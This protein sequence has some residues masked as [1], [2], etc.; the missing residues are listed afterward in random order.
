MKVLFAV[1]NEEIS[2]QIVKRYQ[3][4][5][6]EIISY[7]NV[8]Y[9]NAILKELQRDKSYDRIVISEDLEPFANNNYEM[10]DKFIFEKLDRISDEA[11]NMGNDIPIIL[12]SIERRTKSE[13]ILVKLF[14]LGIYNVLIGQDR[15]ISE[16]CKLLNK[17]R[18]K[19]DAK[20]YYKIES[21]EVNYQSENEDSVSE[22]EIQNILEHYRKL[23]NNQEKFVESFN[24][25]AAQYT[26]AQL[27]IIIK[28]LPLNVKA[29]L[30]ASSPKYQSIMT[31]SGIK[32]V[33]NVQKEMNKD[34]G[35]KIGFIESNTQK[36]K[37]GKPIVVPTALNIQNVKK[38]K[39]VK[40]SANSN[41]ELLKTNNN[42]TN[43]TPEQEDVNP[44]TKKGRG[45]PKK[46]VEQEVMLNADE[47]ENNIKESNS[48]VLESQKQE[49]AIIE[50]VAKK[51]R[52]RP[53]K[54]VQAV[55]TID[56]PQ[57]VKES[58]NDINTQLNNKKT[59]EPKD[60]ENDLLKL[61]Q[62]DLDENDS[63]ED[64]LENLEVQSAIINEEDDM[65]PGVGNEIADITD[66][67]DAN[68]LP[69]FD[70]NQNTSNDDYILPGVDD[71]LDD[72]TSFLPNTNNNISNNFSEINNDDDD[73]LDNLGNV[74]NSYNNSSEITNVENVT[75]YS[76]DLYG[77]LLTK[78]KKIVSFVGTSKNGT[79]FL[80]NNLA[81]LI[82]NMSIKTAI[83]DLTTNKNSYY[84]YTNNDEKLRN[85]A[86]DSMRNLKDGVAKGIPINK[87]LDVYTSLPDSNFNFQISEII[88]TLIK[89]YSLILIDCDFNTPIETFNISQEIYVV[90]SFDILTIQPMTAFLRDLKAKEIL[91]QEKIRIVLNKVVKMRGITSKAIIG[92]LSNY[93]DP[94]MSFMTELFSRDTV[95]YCE[96]SFDE[97]TYTRYLEGVVNC[98][99]SLNGYS[100]VFKEQ[101][102]NLGNMVY[103]LLNNK[104]K[105]YNNYNNYNNG[106]SV[107]I[108]NTLEQMKK[109]Y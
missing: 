25:I 11:N 50:P 101:L 109:Q 71:D 3:K 78:E 15:K 81:Q 20:L 65:L 13:P 2:S 84:I 87:N 10:V 86:F 92:G 44:I 52:G 98:E 89:N 45:R 22:V 33:K 38:I 21:E 63:F 6:K 83:L 60:E 99:V 17:P 41:N 58:V 16:I 103:P 74:N 23:G 73:E 9:F 62:D 32:S 57:I 34:D 28:F 80:V 64:D 72:D 31:F 56:Q 54:V 82:S 12:I 39:P 67:G 42:I 77:G 75:S 55:N 76:N 85:I 51:G 94:A 79:S 96:I 104:S 108:N 30:E 91:K 8:Y 4:D 88:A 37:I 1:N 48:Q 24:S 100:K 47:Q 40:Q 93:N 61:W 35:L 70:D 29:V 107:D 49:N 5:Y 90:Q 105:N 26:D 97:Q 46:V 36:Q 19:K 53:K 102:S 43:T 106:F 18:S 69:G 59:N 66:T 68:F 14:G 7:K 27:K 95:K